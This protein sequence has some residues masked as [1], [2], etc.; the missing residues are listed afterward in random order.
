MFSETLQFASNNPILTVIIL[1]LVGSVIASIFESIFKK[2]MSNRTIKLKLYNENPYCYYCGKKT[3]LTNIKN[4]PK[5][6]ELPDNAATIEHLVSRIS[7]Y[8]FVKKKKGE[9]RKVISCYRCNHDRSIQE[10]LCLSRSVIL[11]RSK[12]FSFSPRGKPKIKK[13]LPTLEAVKKA[14]DL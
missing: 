12:G 11:K 10:T 14:L 6:S 8:R 1:F 3:I 7:L 4:I 13:T 2:Y 9:R 5:G